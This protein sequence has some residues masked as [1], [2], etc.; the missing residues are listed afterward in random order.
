[1][2]TTSSQVDPGHQ[3]LPPLVIDRPQAIAQLEALGYQEGE[4]IYLRFF[5]PDSDPRKTTDQG[6]KLQGKIPSLPWKEIE[7][8]QTEGRGCYFVVNGGGHKDSDV[9]QCRA[10][11]YEHDD[12]DKDIQRDLWQ[13]LGLPEPTIQVDSGGKS[14][15]NYWRLKEPCSV[16]QWR[17]LQT[18]LLEYASADRTLKNPS[19]VMRL[20]GAYHLKPGRDPIQ[21]K[22]L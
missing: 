6:R 16:E 11:F 7:R 17:K 3:P 4:T 10:I 15:H 8:L 13:T 22:I 1:V 21:S 5:F 18:D 9:T 19:R 12:L 20:A 14:I 2:N